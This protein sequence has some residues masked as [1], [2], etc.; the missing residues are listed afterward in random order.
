MIKMNDDTYYANVGLLFC[1]CCGSESI[2]SIERAE[3]FG[4]QLYC[5]YCKSDR[6]EISVQTTD[7]NRVD[8]HFGAFTLCEKL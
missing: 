3:K 7:A 8:F 6:T 4:K 2:I 1:N 5:P